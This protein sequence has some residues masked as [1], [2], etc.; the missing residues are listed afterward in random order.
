MAWNNI[1]DLYNDVLLADKP[2][3]DAIIAEIK[4]EIETR[5]TANQD[6]F[7]DYDPTVILAG[8]EEEKITRVL[9]QVQFYFR[10]IGIRCLYNPPVVPSTTTYTVHVEWFI[11]HKRQYM[12]SYF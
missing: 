6:F 2:L 10:T 1:Y 3:V 8:L 9:E 5:T 4:D 11:R 12:K 7:F